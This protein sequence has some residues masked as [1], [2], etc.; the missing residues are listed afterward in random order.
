G[1]SRGR[2]AAPR[3]TSVERS[4]RSALRYG[5]GRRR[6]TG[7]TGCAARSER[8]PSSGSSPVSPASCEFAERTGAAAA[9]FVVL[10]IGV[11]VIEVFVFIEVGRAIGWLLAVLLLFGTPVLGVRIPR[12]QRRA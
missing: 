5:R 6:W 4:P 12:I 2:P 1:D 11:P 10:L 8:A 7:S 9:M 3:M